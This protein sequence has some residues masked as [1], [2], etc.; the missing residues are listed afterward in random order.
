MYA[1]EYNFDI[2]K[3]ESIQFEFSYHPSFQSQ[4]DTPYLT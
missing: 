3:R 1:A 2:P 4:I